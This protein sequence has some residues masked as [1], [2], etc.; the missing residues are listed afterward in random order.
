M[1]VS[2]IIVNYKTPTLLK[3]CIASIFKQTVGVNFEIIVVDNDSNDGSGS[4]INQIFPSI[5]FIQSGSNLG[6]GK[7]NNIGI[8]KVTG[9][10]IFFL[11]SDTVLINNAIKILSDYLDENVEVG[12]CGGNLFDENGVP[13]HSHLKIS[14]G[15]FYELNQI[16]FS[17]YSKFFLK[18]LHFNFEE[19]P[20]ETS[21]VTGADMMVKKSIIDIVGGF[22]PDFFLYYEETE[23]QYR[24]S[25]LGYKIMNVP[26]SKI[27][28]LE[29]ASITNNEQKINLILNSYKLYLSKIYKFTLIQKL[30]IFLFKIKCLRNLFVYIIIN[31]EQK[32][33][34]WL[35]N[36]KNIL[37]NYNG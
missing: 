13:T 36:Y 27:I 22:D 29:G 25:K 1:D 34:Y 23:L 35:I 26:Q 4:L 3:N 24:I 20:I 31:N 32:K 33:N 16:F 15:F 21:Y 14:P 9:R 28:H 17:F 2:I 12:V 18:N 8:K 30:T 6:F 11:N 10:N 19:N 37:K 7:A 5:T